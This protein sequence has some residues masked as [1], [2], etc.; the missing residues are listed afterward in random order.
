VNRFDGKELV[1]GRK[2]R[3]Q[4]VRAAHQ[5]VI[6]NL[7]TI[8]HMAWS[9]LEQCPMVR[10]NGRRLHLPPE[11]GVDMY[12]MSTETRGP[13]MSVSVDEALGLSS[14]GKNSTAYE[15][16]MQPVA[17]VGESRSLFSL[18]FDETQNVPNVRSAHLLV[19]RQPPATACSE[20][21][22]VA[23]R[24]R[25]YYKL[26]KLC[27]EKPVVEKKSSIGL[28][29]NEVGRRRCADLTMKH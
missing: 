16:A 22:A 21:G 6:K 25:L 4:V 17:A 24:Y 29:H 14:P 10:I 2:K 12:D 5:G 19:V 8:N 3:M 28:A 23:D 26:C 7:L 1:D 13:W 11:V 9:R 20:R 27:G 18:L 15:W